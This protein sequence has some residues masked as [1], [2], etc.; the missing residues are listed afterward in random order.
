MQTSKKQGKDDNPAPLSNLDAERFT[1]GAAMIDKAAATKV[2]DTVSEEYF[3]LEKHRI[4]FRAMRA[5]AMVKVAIDRVTLCDRLM[6]EGNLESVDGVSYVTSLDDGLPQISNIESYIGIL[7]EKCALRRALSI[8]EA[9]RAEVESGVYQSKEIIDGLRKAVYESFS[10]DETSAVGLVSIGKF[11]ETFPGGLNELLQPHRKNQGIPTGF[12]RFDE[13]T[14][15]FHD[16]EIFMV[17]AYASTGKTVFLLQLAQNVA[18]RFLVEMAD[19]CVAVFSLEMSRRSVFNR[20]VCR[21]ARVPVIRFRRGELSEA[22][23]VRVQEA[24]TFISDLPL[25]IADQSGL[26]VSEIASRVE[27]IED[28]TGKEVG[29]VGI[30][31]VQIMKGKKNFSNHADRMTDIADGLQHYTKSSKK[32]LLVLSQLSR[33]SDKQTIRKPILSDLKYS[34]SLENI[35]NVIAFLWREEIFNKK[36]VELRGKAELLVAKNRDGAT[37]E[38]P[39]TYTAWNMKFEEISTSGTFAPEE[40]TNLY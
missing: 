36:K 8:S 2:L 25:F 7:R 26:T 23:R 39:M 9:L 3:S 5:L 10:T 22:E 33:Q 17:G 19:K 15:G 37:D 35:S 12:T 14:D 20:L 11:V 27:Q 16:Q 24:T 29:L 21:A 1:L 28:E 32:P 18:E 31:Y 38:I 4:I 34:G 13:L 40:Q 6:A 30:D